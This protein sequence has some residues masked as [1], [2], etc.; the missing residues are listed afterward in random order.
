VNSES[1][2][3][4]YFEQVVDEICATFSIS[5]KPNFGQ[6]FLARVYSP[7]SE[8]A[9]IEEFLRPFRSWRE[10]HRE[11]LRSYPGDE[12]AILTFLSPSAFRYYLPAF[13]ISALECVFDD[14]QFVLAINLGLQIPAVRQEED[15]EI[16]RARLGKFQMLTDEEKGAVRKYLKAV[17]EV[18]LDDELAAQSALKTYWQPTES[19]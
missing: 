3:G 8:Y 14:R 6:L 13:L 19:R 10:I 11:N 12:T 15:L 4:G 18:E 1:N 5:P 9:M 17:R 16:V 2:F 7:D